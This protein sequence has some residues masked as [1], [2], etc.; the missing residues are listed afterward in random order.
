MVPSNADSDVGE[1]VFCDLNELTLV[2]IIFVKHKPNPP[3][4]SYS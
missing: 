4:V 3:R 2:M 1:I